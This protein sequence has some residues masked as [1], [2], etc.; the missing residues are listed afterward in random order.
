MALNSYPKAASM[1]ST[2]EN[3]V[4]DEGS[5]GP[6]MSEQEIDANYKLLQQ[7]LPG[8]RQEAN[9]LAMGQTYEQLDKGEEGRL[10]KRGQERVPIVQ[11][12]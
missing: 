1:S 2:L 10:G 3:L 6:G 5:V 12:G 7:L 8:E 11:E 9:A 4:Q